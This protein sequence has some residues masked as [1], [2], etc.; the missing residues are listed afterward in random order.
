MLLMSYQSLNIDFPHLGLVQ[1]VAFCGP[2]VFYMQNWMG[3]SSVLIIVR[4][5]LTRG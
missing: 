2:R 5:K 1:A 4:S 3:L